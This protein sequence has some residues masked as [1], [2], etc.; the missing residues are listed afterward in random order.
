MSSPAKSTQDAAKTPYAFVQKG[1]WDEGYSTFKQSGAD[2][3]VQ[4]LVPATSSENRVYLPMGLVFED[5]IIS[6]SAYVV[7]NAPVY[8]LGLLMSRLHMTWLRAIGGKLETRYRYSAGLVYNTFPVPE[9]STKR[10]NQIEE[11][12]FEILDLREELGGTLAELYHRDT[13]PQ[14]LREAHQV[15]DGI[16][17]RAY[18]ETPFT[19]D[20][21]R[22]SHLLKRYKEIKEQS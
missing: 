10:K 17:E 19:S 7:Y 14:A 18:K 5:T 9:L 3:F 11:Q 6:N 8:L 20:E 15:L 1:E 2:E 4:L 16:V 22:L 21:E 12:V 13:M